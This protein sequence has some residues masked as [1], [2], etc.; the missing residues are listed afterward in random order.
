[1]ETK[2][3]VYSNSQ[4]VMISSGVFA[5]YDELE[6][7]IMLFDETN[8]LTGEVEIKKMVDGDITEFTVDELPE[9]Y[10]QYA[11]W[12]C[13]TPADFIGKT[14]NI[15]GHA[16]GELPAEIDDNSH[17]DIDIL[18]T[19]VFLTNPGDSITNAI[20]RRLNIDKYDHSVFTINYDYQVY[21]NGN[22]IEVE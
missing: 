1:M 21:F 7:A 12:F 11:G 22:K 9:G 14:I 20:D 6:P 13:K 19:D 3:S 10:K 2:Y 4:P 17:F 5:E 15:T 16:Y 8:L 18:I